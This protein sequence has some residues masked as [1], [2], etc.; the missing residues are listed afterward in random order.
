MARDTKSLTSFPAWTDLTGADITAITF[1]V[2]GRGAVEFVRAASSPSA[3]PSVDPA[4]FVYQPGEGDR[5]GLDDI[6]PG[7]AGAR[8]WVRSLSGAAV[9]AEWN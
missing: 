6:F 3:D 9:V 2:R 4:A 8:L 7:G 1:Q 5:G